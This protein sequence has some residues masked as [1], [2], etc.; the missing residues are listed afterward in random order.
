MSFPIFGQDRLLLMNGQ[1]VDCRVLSDTSIVME[2]EIA[3]RNG[4]IKRR[5]IH[6]SDVFSYSIGGAQEKI[7]YAQD[8]LYGDVY[9]V[10]EMKIYLAGER[11]ARANYKW[12]PTAAI[13]FVLCGSI[14]YLSGDGYVTTFAPPVLW[15]GAQFIGKI[16]IREKYMSDL[17]YQYNDT[18]A[19]GFEP[20]ARSKK[21]TGA[22]A[23]GFAGAA[24]GLLLW[25][26][27]VGYK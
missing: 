23:G 8:S 27:L 22:V 3:K 21:V 26:A 19:E 25:Y 16:K 24:S 17:N 15:L 9:T 18:Y 4:K 12:W 10:D 5:E 7:L 6:K 13:G 2:V 20:P 1:F 14:A 11:D